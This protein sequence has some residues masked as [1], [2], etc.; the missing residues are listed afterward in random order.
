MRA[1]SPGVDN[2]ESVHLYTSLFG[3][4]PGL[5]NEGIAV[6]FQTDPSA[7]DFV[8]RWSGEPVHDV[9]RRLRSQG[10]LAPI[11]SM[12][13]TRDFLLVPDDVQYPEAGSFVRYL[14]DTHTIELMKALFRLSSPDDSSETVRKNF[15]QIYGMT[16]DRASED[17]L[18]FL[19][20]S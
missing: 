1:D 13:T 9:A 5:F 18:R 7:D 20:T 12:L 16:V 15:E 17:W 10:S 11:S 4:A 14:L 3:S 2:H 19:E 8:P 6:A